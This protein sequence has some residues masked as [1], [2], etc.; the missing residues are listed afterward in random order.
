MSVFIVR[1]MF[2]MAEHLLYK[3]NVLYRNQANLNTSLTLYEATDNTFEQSGYV[4][5]L[6]QLYPHVFWT[7]FH[8][9]PSFHASLHIQNNATA[10]NYLELRKNKK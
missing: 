9:Q 10:I 1:Q 4:N 3:G 7:K 2:W 5:P 6:L 8:I